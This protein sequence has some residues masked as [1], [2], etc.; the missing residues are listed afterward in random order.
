MTRT[1]SSFRLASTSLF[2]AMCLGTFWQN[3]ATAQQPN[4][5]AQPPANLPPAQLPPYDPAPP[6]AVQPPQQPLAERVPQAGERAMEEASRMTQFLNDQFPGILEIDGVD[7]IHAVRLPGDAVRIYGTLASAAQRDRVA[8]VALEIL[9]SPDAQDILDS[10]VNRVDITRMRVGTGSPVVVLMVLES[11]IA[12]V[13]GESPLS[14][15]R[16]QRYEPAL[17]AITLCGIVES[18]PQL[19]H[20]ANQLRNVGRIQQVESTPVLIADLV[21]APGDPTY[22]LAKAMDALGDS[23]GVRLVAAADELLLRGQVE[24]ET[25][26]LRAAGH[27]LSCQ[28]QN[29]IGDL[30]VA[31]LTLVRLRI[32]E[33]FQGVPRQHL[34]HI[35]AHGPEASLAIWQ[36]TVI[37]LW[38]CPPPSSGCCPI[39]EFAQI[40]FGAPPMPAVLYCR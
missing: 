13:L 33:R 4:D 24:P 39:P 5:A 26:Y 29:A 21:T 38:E 30:R 15:V 20:L 16:I 11:L 19:T 37:S 10:P 7:V 22:F 8:D 9:S 40:P 1:G 27:L 2:L 31:G 12:D 36:D 3:A 17:G 23:D 32:L 35:L 25:W 28:Y 34:E 6:G 14:L 18:A